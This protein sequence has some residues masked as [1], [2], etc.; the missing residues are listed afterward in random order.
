MLV[1]RHVVVDL[2]T[3]KFSSF[4]LV[5]R[6]TSDCDWV[7][8]SDVTLQCQYHMLCLCSVNR[9]MVGV[10]PLHH[11]VGGVLQRVMTDIDNTI[12][13]ITADDINV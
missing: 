11:R 12:S 13:F 8:Q 7:Y 5:D 10:A 6:L 1:E 2:N 3:E 9:L 4:G